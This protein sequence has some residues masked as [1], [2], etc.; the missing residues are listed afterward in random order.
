MLPQILEKRGS[1]PASLGQPLE[2]PQI[3][4]RMVLKVGGHEVDVHMSNIYDPTWR[5][6]LCEQDA[7]EAAL[8]VVRRVYN[9]V[10]EERL[11]R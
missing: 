6:G 8:P 11:Y 10:F 1:E 5:I 4:M 2:R 9:A 7:K 3:E